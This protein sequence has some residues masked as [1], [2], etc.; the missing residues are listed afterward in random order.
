[1]RAGAYVD[2]N[3][4]EIQRERAAGCLVGLIAIFSIAGPIALIA[5]RR[6][7]IDDALHRAATERG[8][9]PRREF[10]DVIQLQARIALTDDDQRVVH[11][12]HLGVKAIVA[13]KQCERGRC[14]HQL[15]VARGIESKVVVSLEDHLAGVEITDVNAN[16]GVLGKS[17]R[18]ALQTAGEQ[19]VAAWPSQ[20]RAESGRG[21]GA[22][23]LAAT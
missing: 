22:F 10:V 19:L 2:L 15:L 8:V 7:I 3:R 21:V 1:M 14:R 9:G 17:R 20:A 4:V 16:T 11:E 13:A 23:S 12:V 18:D 6:V 5:K